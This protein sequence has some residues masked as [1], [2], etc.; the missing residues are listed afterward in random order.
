MEQLFPDLWQT[1]RWSAVSDG[2]GHLPLRI[3]LSFT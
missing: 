3:V 2:P 1:Q